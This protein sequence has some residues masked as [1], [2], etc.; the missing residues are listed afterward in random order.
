MHPQNAGLNH[1]LYKFCDT[2]SYYTSQLRAAEPIKATKEFVDDQRNTA[3]R[4]ATQMCRDLMY[5]AGSNRTMFYTN[6]ENG[7]DLSEDLPIEYSEVSDNNTNT[8]CQEVF[9]IPEAQATCYIPAKSMIRKAQNTVKHDSETSH[10]VTSTPD[11]C[12][13][14]FDF[15]E[16]LEDWS[17]PSATCDDLHNY[18]RHAS[19]ED[20]LHVHQ[21]ETAF[22]NYLSIVPQTPSMTSTEERLTYMHL[23]VSTK[24]SDESLLQ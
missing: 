11:S 9:V 8:D 15:F 22:Q 13:K 2:M 3:R 19:M 18:R 6:T 10:T 1:K 21:S 4:K 12:Q 16:T 5:T 14:D 7:V 23:T 20:S 24:P 17:L